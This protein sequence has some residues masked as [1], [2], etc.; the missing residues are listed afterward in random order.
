M[1]NVSLNAS[2][3]TAY[4]FHGLIEFLLTT[5]RDEDVC[6]LFYKVLCCSEP[7][8]GC[9]TSNHGMVVSSPFA[10]RIDR[11]LGGAGQCAV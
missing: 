8:S 5:A 1:E 3:I 6:A 4:C 7:Y 2:D 11:S 10:S 9:A